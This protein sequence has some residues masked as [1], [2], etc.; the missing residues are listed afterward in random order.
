MST[1]T[2]NVSEAKFKRFKA[3][4]IYPPVCYASYLII[5]ILCCRSVSPSSGHIDGGTIL[6]ISGSNLGVSVNDVSVLIGTIECPLLQAEYKPGMDYT[7]ELMIIK[8]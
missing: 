7:I 4:S 6:T 2:N 5:I 8:F 3:S 1:A